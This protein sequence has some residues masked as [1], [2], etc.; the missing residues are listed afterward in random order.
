MLPP[1]YAASS[2]SA[3]VVIVI[4]VLMGLIFILCIV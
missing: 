1:V 3:V 4:A 2:L